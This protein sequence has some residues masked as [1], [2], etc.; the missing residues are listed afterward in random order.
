MR[1]WREHG[2]RRPAPSALCLVLHF[3][4]ESSPRSSNPAF[5]IRATGSRVPGWRVSST[6][7]S[8][9]VASTHLRVHAIARS[10]AETTFLSPHRALPV[11]GS[12]L[13]DLVGSAS[14]LRFSKP[15]RR[16]LASRPVRS[17]SRLTTIR[18]RRS[19]SVQ[20]VT[21]ANRSGCYG[22]ER[23]LPGGSAPRW[24][25]VPSRCDVGSVLTTGAVNSPRGS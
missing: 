10:P 19:P 13:R 8:F 23:K 1:R 25:A 18:F 6:D 21:S 7:K 2:F 24:G 22:L 9:R 16:S 5:A 4:Y 20:F 17:L 3:D 15:A 12:L 14:A 11:A